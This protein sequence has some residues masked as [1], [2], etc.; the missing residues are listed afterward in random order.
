MILLALEMLLKL[1]GGFDPVISCVSIPV[2]AHGPRFL[3]ENE[4]E[5]TLEEKRKDWRE[6]Y[7]K[8]RDKHAIG[9]KKWQAENSEKV[10]TYKIKYLLANPEKHREAV[11]RWQFANKEKCRINQN[12]WRIAHPEKVQ[13]YSRKYAEKNKEKLIIRRK[14]YRDT[15][16]EQC[17]NRS[18]KWASENPERRR[19]LASRRRAF[20]QSSVINQVSYNKILA[21]DG[22]ICHICK[23]DIL[24]F[25]KL[26]FDH[27]IPLVKGGAHSMENIKPSHAKC[28]MS[29]G[30]KLL[31]IYDL[32]VKGAKR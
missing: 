8:N 5:K 27:V 11:R 29:K 2:S 30:M 19:E 14:K 20:K 22:R 3:L 4:M 25:D 12:E 26:H 28:N 15:H 6:Y 16:L 21:R 1:G 32:L 10:R 18:K 13:I 17:K 24:L 9:V 23:K 31:G 7:I